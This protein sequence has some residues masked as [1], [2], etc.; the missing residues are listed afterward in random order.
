MTS[1]SK[2]PTDEQREWVKDAIKKWRYILRLAD[3]RITINYAEG[4]HSEGAAVQAENT[5]NPFYLFGKINIFPSFFD[6]TSEEEREESLVHELVHFSLEHM[7][8]LITDVRAGQLV[9]NDHQTEVVETTVSRF[10]AILTYLEK[11]HDNGRGAI[12]ESGGGDPAATP[13][14][15]GSEQGESTG[16]SAEGASGG[17]AETAE[18][19]GRQG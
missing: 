6:G 8:R 11:H 9:T 17:E 10:A 4:E 1:P 18:G 14:A 16:D 7:S 5:S 13:D 12:T 3:Y 19:A 15:T 2:F